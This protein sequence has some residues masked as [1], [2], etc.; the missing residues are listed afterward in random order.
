MFPWPDIALLIIRGA[1]GIL[2]DFNFWLILALVGYQYWQM[3]KRQ[4]QMFGVYNYTLTQQILLAGF[5]GLVGGITGS[6]LLTLVGVTLNQLGLAYIWPVALGL[7]LIN[8]RFLCFAYAGGLVALSNVLFGWPDVN[9]P[10]VLSLV[11]VL[12]ITESLL[13]AISGGYSAMPMIIKKADGRL[14]GAFSLQNFWPLPLVILAAVA[15]PTDTTP[16]GIIKMPEWWPLLP[17]SLEPP[18]G[19][20]WIYVMAP[21]VAALGYTD[22]AIASLPQ[23]RRWQS[24]LNLAVYSIILLALALLAAKYSWLKAIAAVLSPVGHELL[25]QLDNRREMDAPPRFVPPPYGVMALDTVLDTP[26]AKVL[27]PGDIITNLGGIPVNNRYDL[28]AAIS[29]V[30]EQFSIAFERDGK[31]LVKDIRFKRGERRLGVIL[32][33][34]GDEQF[35]AEMTDERYGL[36]DWIIDKI[37]RR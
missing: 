25:I 2:F 18:A 6:F 12:H 16:G 33:P 13:I 7:M 31:D 24:A 32:V 3:Q 11:A 22:M 27:K 21:V 8:M 15:V 10:Q 35:Y 1:F 26:A 37:K 19:S 36:I 4:R 28:A 17:L 34:D 30:P 5:Y 29:H 14:V 23:Q 9:V 20:S